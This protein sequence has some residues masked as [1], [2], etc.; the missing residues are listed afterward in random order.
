MDTKTVALVSLLLILLPVVPA[1]LLNFPAFVATSA[2]GLVI[3]LYIMITNRTWEDLKSMIV[4]TY[5]TGVFAAGITLGV[6]FALYSKPRLFAELGLIFSL[7]FIV[8][9]ILLLRRILPNIIRKDILYFSNGYLPLLIVIIIG[10]IIGRFISSFYSLLILYSGT[11]V[12]G[13]LLF[14]YFRKG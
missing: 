9:F 3:V 13:I 6:F 2:I 4:G 1:Y 10:A 5:F 11:I 12:I 8:Q 14:L 7:P